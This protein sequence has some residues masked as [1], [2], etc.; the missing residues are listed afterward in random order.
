MSSFI[1][2][3]SAFLAI[4]VLAGVVTPSVAVAQQEPARLYQNCMAMAQTKP[5]RA[6]G[7]ATRWEGLG[8]GHPARYCALVALMNMGRYGEAAQGFE[9]LADEVRAS[10]PFK[11]Q[12]LARAAEGWLLLGEEDMSLDV[13]DT[14]IKLDP[15]DADLLIVRSQVLA[16]KGAYWEAADDL[17]RVIEANPDNADALAF[18]AAAWRHLDTLDL[19]LSDAERALIAAPE[20]PGGLLERGN[21]YRM[22]GKNDAA[23]KDWMAVITAWPETAAAGSA[24]QNLERM[25]VKQR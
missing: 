6:F 11:A 13:I 23:R 16:A 8:G 22:Q 12:V 24:R 14:A 4:T 20:H 25:D 19:A 21:I 9:R 17:G 1:N 2:N 15:T 7:E 10:A 3:L 18:R 5:E